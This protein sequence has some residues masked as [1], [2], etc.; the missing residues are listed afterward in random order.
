VGVRVTE[1]LKVVL[2]D[3]FGALLAG[4]IPLLIFLFVSAE[5]IVPGGQSATAWWSKFYSEL[6]NHLLVI[7][8][9]T[10]TVSTFA[11]VPRLVKGRGSPDGALTLIMVVTIVL[12]ISVAMYVLRQ[13]NVAPIVSLWGVGFLSALGLVLAAAVTSY[14]LAVTVTNLSLRRTGRNARTR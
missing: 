6:V 2:W 9:V 14:Y 5:A 11:S 4:A 13:T 10:S 12:V 7:S 1:E 3:W 8:I